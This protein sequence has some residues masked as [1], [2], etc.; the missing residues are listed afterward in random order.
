[1]KAPYCLSDYSISELINL[2]ITAR[3]ERA[4]LEVGYPAT[5]IVKSREIEIEGPAVTPEAIA[6]LVRS[7]AC[8]RQIR[9]LRKYGTIEAIYTFKGSRFLVRAVD[10]FGDCRL[11]LQP[12][13]ALIN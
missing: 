10:A 6:E 3:A 4:R 1:M 13:V 7:V 2:L 11:D 9:N 8:T 12:V 5:L